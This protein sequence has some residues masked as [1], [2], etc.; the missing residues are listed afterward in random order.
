MPYFVFMKKS[1]SFSNLLYAC[2]VSLTFLTVLNPQQVVSKHMVGVM[3]ETIEIN[4]W[5]KRKDKEWLVMEVDASN[6]W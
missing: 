6:L 4:T 2:F 1:W 3:M 5:K